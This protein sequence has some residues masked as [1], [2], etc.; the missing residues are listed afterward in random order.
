MSDI[1]VE[2]LVE[3]LNKTHWNNPLIFNNIVEK[4]GKVDPT[5]RNEDFPILMSI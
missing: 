4:L 2:D 5:L 3:I 1:M